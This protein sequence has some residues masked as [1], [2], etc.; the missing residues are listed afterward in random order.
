MY[1]VSRVHSKG[2]RCLFDCTIAWI[3]PSFQANT[4]PKP[5]RQPNPTS[6][7]SGDYLRRV[8]GDGVRS[9]RL[10]PRF[11]TQQ[12]DPAAHQEFSRHCNNRFFLASLLPASKSIFSPRRSSPSVPQ[13][14]AR[15]TKP[16]D[17][18][19]RTDSVAV[20]GLRMTRPGVR[21]ETGAGRQYRRRP[22]PPSSGPRL[23]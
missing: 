13:P 23:E 22:L 3:R 19:R 8:S 11:F 10:F 5:N 21:F 9:Q 4:A 2:L 15:T 16:A 6:G 7:Y 12:H 18:S 17:P 14:P 20:R 1:A